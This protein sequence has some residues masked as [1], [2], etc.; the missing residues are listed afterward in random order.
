M[1][2]DGK[3]AKYR[4]TIELKSDDHRVRTSHMLGDDGRWQP[5]MAVNYRRTK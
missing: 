5:F 4:D 1:T 2:G 3:M